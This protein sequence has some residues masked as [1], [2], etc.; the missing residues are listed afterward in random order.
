MAKLIILILTFCVTPPSNGQTID[1]RIQKEI[2]ILRQSHIDTFLIYSV[3]CVG[4]E[5]I[6][7]DDTCSNEEQS[8]YLLWK[9]STIYYLQKFDFCK[10][11]KPVL[12]DTLNALSF[13]LLY[14]SKIDQEEIKPPTYLKST[15]VEIISLV[16]HTWFY[17]M[18]FLLK[19]K[20]VFKK[21]SHYDLTFTTFDNGRES[22]YALYNQ[23]T[24]LKKLIEL[25]DQMDTEQMFEKK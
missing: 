8:W 19:D 18:T 10:N 23:H 12:L 20:K 2:D 25:I 9:K 16:D 4:C 6:V 7:S 15:N 14:S 1:T 11:Y 24:K 21:V 22:M 17:E 5:T 13:Y 3:P